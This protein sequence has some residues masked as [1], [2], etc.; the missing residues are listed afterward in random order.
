MKMNNKSLI[1][2]LTLTLI[3]STYVAAVW[4]GTGGIRIDP[5]LPYMNG[6]PAD[7][8]VE[9]KG[10]DDACNPIV[11][12]VMTEA[13]YN[14]LHADVIVSWDGGFITL[15]D[16]K[17]ENTDG[18]K[19]PPGTSSGAGYTVASL[20]DHL[21]T[22]DPIYWDTAP[23]IGSALEAGEEYEITVGLASDSPKMLVYVLGQSD[24]GGDYDMRVPPTIP[25]FVIPEVPL[26]TL[27][28]ALTMLGAAGLY[29][30]KEK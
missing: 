30:L 1:V 18:D 10:K 13:C 12:L 23:I 17:M 15:N 24:C 25:G 4:A 2:L 28:S 9:V 3:F 8:T 11:F 6:S 7:F 27:L 16:W 21:D 22:S 20:K 19:V 26:G 14:S 29:R 5:P